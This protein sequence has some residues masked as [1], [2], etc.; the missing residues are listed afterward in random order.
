MIAHDQAPRITSQ[1]ALETFVFMGIF[2]GFLR[3]SRKGTQPLLLSSAFSHRFPSGF[4]AGFSLRLSKSKGGRINSIHI[5]LD[6]SDVML[7]SFKVY[8]YS[9]F[10]LAT[11]V[12][13]IPQFCDLRHATNDAISRLRS[14]FALPTF[15]S[16]RNVLVL[17]FHA[18]IKLLN[19]LIWTEID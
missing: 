8:A 13:A 5:C 18:W 6:L 12:A 2:I 15:F 19:R 10:E 9:R 16:A 11:A 4:R 7:Y 14:F 3:V 17:V 1:S